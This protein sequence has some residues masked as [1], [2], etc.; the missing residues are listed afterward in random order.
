MAEEA[1]DAVDALR[2]KLLAEGLN[3]PGMIDIDN[4]D[5]VAEWYDYLRIKRTAG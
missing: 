3:P 4:K 2:P 1:Q 5:S